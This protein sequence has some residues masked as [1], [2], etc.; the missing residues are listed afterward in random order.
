MAQINCF[1]FFF[2]YLA[3]G[4][5]VL[6]EFRVCAVLG[7]EVGAQVD[8]LVNQAAASHLLRHDNQMKSNKQ[9]MCGS[10]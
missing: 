1:F 2:S 3:I 7:D 10:A 8:H 6:V 5:D 9:K 4:H